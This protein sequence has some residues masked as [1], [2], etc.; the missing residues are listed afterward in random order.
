MHTEPLEQVKNILRRALAKIAG[1]IL[2]YRGCQRKSLAIKFPTVFPDKGQSNLTAPLS[3]TIDQKSSLSSEFLVVMST[4]SSS[5][6]S[7]R[8]RTRRGVPSALEHNERISRLKAKLSTASC[9][10]YRTREAEDEAAAQLKRIERRMLDAGSSSA[11]YAAAIRKAVDAAAH[12]DVP[13]LSEFLAQ[14][15]DV[16][17]YAQQRDVV[18]KERKRCKDKL[19]EER[20]ALVAATAREQLEVA[21]GRYQAAVG[22]KRKAS[23]MSQKVQVCLTA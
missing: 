5:A 3:F 21:Q 9:R 8:A 4:T 22:G 2:S 23:F 12:E 17:K 11:R 6:S 10:M 20:A 15:S 16:V 1:S 7:G 18:K 19:K 13:L 14:L